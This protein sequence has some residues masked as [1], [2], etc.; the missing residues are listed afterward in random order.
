[1]S[2]TVSGSLLCMKHGLEDLKLGKQKAALFQMLVRGSLWT[3]DLKREPAGP[4]PY[5]GG[6][7]LHSHPSPYLGKG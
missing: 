4:L 7:G 3:H 1:M 6:R 2:F 5:L